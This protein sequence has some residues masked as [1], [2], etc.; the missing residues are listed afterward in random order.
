MDAIPGQAS[1]PATRKVLRR[2]LEVFGDRDFERLARLSNGHLHNL[3]RS[4]PY[5]AVRTTVEPTRAAKV[6]IGEPCMYHVHLI[7]I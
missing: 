4:R 6:A 7:T 1:G 5:R 2:M 3:R